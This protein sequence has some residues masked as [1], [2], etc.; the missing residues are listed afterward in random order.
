MGLVLNQIH[1]VPVSFPDVQ[2]DFLYISVFSSANLE[3]KRESLS[4]L[5]VPG[6]SLQ[7]R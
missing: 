3:I 2:L 7:I 1:L 6:F 4:F 5:G